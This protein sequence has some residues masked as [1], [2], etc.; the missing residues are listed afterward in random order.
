M[1]PLKQEVSP[2]TLGTFIE[3]PFN[4][5][6]ERIGRPSHGDKKALLVPSPTL[7]TKEADGQRQPRSLLTDS[8]GKLVLFGLFRYR[9]TRAR[10]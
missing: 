3:V 6:E 9:E 7:S 5:K 10:S 2:A 4:T 1:V 8:V